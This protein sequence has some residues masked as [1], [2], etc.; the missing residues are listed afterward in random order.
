MLQVLNVIFLL[1]YLEGLFTP[2]YIYSTSVFTKCLAVGRT[3]C[4]SMS[5]TSCLEQRMNRNNVV[6]NSRNVMIRVN[7]RLLEVTYKSISFNLSI[8]YLIF[9]LHYS[10]VLC[11]IWTLWFHEFLI[12][13]LLSLNIAFNIISAAVFIG[14][15]LCL[16]VVVII[17][18]DVVPLLIIMYGNK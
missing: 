13:Q 12:L 11:T 1:I 6:N 17:L 14:A 8:I 15:P 9:S 2:I 3:I 7:V 5:Q 10:S 16:F 18:N 4:R